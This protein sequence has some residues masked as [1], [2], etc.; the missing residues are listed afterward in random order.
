VNQNEAR[1][2]EESLKKELAKRDIEYFIENFVYIEDKDNAGI[3]IP[4]KLWEVDCSPYLNQKEALRSMLEHRL[5][6]VLK[7][8][9]LGFTWMAL[10][11]IAH[12]II[13]NSGYT[14]VA[15]SKTEDPDSYELTR[16]VD[17]ILRYLPESWGI[18]WDYKASAIEIKHKGK[19][20]SIFQSF[21]AGPN[22]GR[23]FTANIVLLDEWAFQQWARKI[24]SAAYPTINRPTGGKVIGLSTIELGTLFCEIWTDAVKGINGF[25]P[26]FVPWKADPRRD[27]K[28]YEATKKALP[29]TYRA[30]YPATPEEAFTVGEGAFFEEWDERIHVPVKH[31]QPPN[32]NKRW[33]IVGAYDPG[34][35]S[36]ACFKWYAISPDGWARCFKEYYPHRVIDRDQAIKIIEMSVYS[37]GKESDKE[38]EV[39]GINGIEKVKVHLTGTPYNFEYIVA[40][41]DAW[42][43]SRE[44]GKSTAQTF[45]EF[46]LGMT[47]ANKDL[48][49]GWMRLHE[50][51]QPF[52]GQSGEKT[53]LLT[54]TSDC[55]NTI[56]TYPACVSSETDPEDISKKS[57][58]HPQDVDRYF[59]MS[60]P[61][62]KKYEK[63][64]YEI[65]CEKF[66][67]DSPEAMKYRTLYGTG[68]NKKVNPLDVM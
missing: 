44:G 26:I 29:N 63:T 21:S 56:R 22:S 41:T 64:E 5:N 36:N 2:A 10:A 40:D 53:A 49:N 62:A 12:Q 4:F 25:N 54:F 1:I 30:E 20:N 39:S 16:R 13:F 33:S 42:T 50:W 57:E 11:I 23:S 8:R 43:P 24:W 31:W 3:P 51:L 55:K 46:G 6:I 66:G 14:A 59:V 65:I 45:A 28:W 58:H 38:F 7:A 35:A 32:D 48:K 19:E 34:F 18:K 17:F 68:K 52:D 60:R 67:E 27:Q 9:Q 47:K 15:L 61:K 37:D